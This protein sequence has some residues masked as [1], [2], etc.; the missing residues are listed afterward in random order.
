VIF[1]IDPLQ[2]KIFLQLVLAALLGGVLGLE[3]DYVG[4]PVGLRTYALVSLGSALFTIVSIQSIKFFPGMPFDPSRIPAQIVTGIGFIGAGIIIHQG[5]RAK[6]I[7]T[8][9]GLWLVSAIGVAVGFDL[10]QIAIFATI[11]AFIIIVVLRFVDW[12]KELKEVVEKI[13]GDKTEDLPTTPI[14][15]E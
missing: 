5:L 7:T 4:K 14:S 9:A 2:L 11:L 1:S 15:K 6:G 12:E 3:R 13:K 8:A 10:D